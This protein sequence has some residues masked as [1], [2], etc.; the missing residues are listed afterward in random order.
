MVKD[1]NKYFHFKRFFSFGYLFLFLL[2]YT[3]KD[4]V[5]FGVNSNPIFYQFDLVIYFA[6]SIPVILSFI[7]GKYRKYHIPLLV[8]IISFLIT[9]FFTLSFSGGFIF[10][11]LLFIIAIYCVEKWSFG[12]FCKYFEKIVFL[13]TIISIIFYVIDL[14][15]I[16]IP[17]IQVVNSVSSVINHWLIYSVN[18]EGS[19][20][21]NTSIFREPGVYMIYINLALLINMYILENKHNTIRYVVYFIALFTT[22]ST[23]G[24]IIGLIILLL[25][26]INSNNNIKYLF[27][28]FIIILLVFGYGYYSHLNFFEKSFGKLNDFENATGSSFARLASV[29]V[30][31][32]IC[33][34]NFW[35]VG[36]NNFERFYESSSYNMYGISLGT[37]L[38]T[39]T[40]TNMFARYGWVIGFA[41]LI[42]IFSLSKLFLTK[43]SFF[44]FCIFCLFLFNEDV[45]DSIIFTI[46]L[47]YGMKRLMSKK[48]IQYYLNPHFVK[49]I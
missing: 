8:V 38:S 13:F 26:I 29:T 23:A 30:P 19:F 3:S 12:D 21:R 15:G 7:E 41:F 39:N 44:V 48:K 49:S 42:C 25:K 1:V 14:I 22:Y 4:T 37:G 34:S 11:I 43:N 2:F 27:I 33:W 46:F 35:G 10:H 20:L 47:C 45:W 24:Y 36:F 9:I 16:I 18:T 5:L 32:K 40:I 28:G 6:I 31:M 17:S